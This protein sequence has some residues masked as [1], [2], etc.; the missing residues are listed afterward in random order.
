MRLRFMAGMSAAALAALALGSPGIGH[1]QDSG[2]VS[3]NAPSVTH[4]EHASA[5]DRE[6]AHRVS[7]A[8]KDDPN[9]F[10][11]HVTVHVKD[12]VVTLGGKVGSADAM[13]SAKKLVQNV[14]GVTEVKSEMTM[15]HG[16]AQTSGGH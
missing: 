12:G 8:L 6:T 11:R 2:S 10:Y 4:E 15:S 1:A 7:Q 3:P 16:E 14:Q 9:H 13:N 5:S